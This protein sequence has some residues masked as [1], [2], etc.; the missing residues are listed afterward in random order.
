MLGIYDT[1]L[2]GLAVTKEILKLLPEL[3]LVYLADQNSLPL[4]SKTGD[5]IQAIT[6]NGVEILFG[7]GCDLVLLACNTATVNTIRHLQQVWLL[8]QNLNQTHNI[9]GVSQP[10]L[11]ILED[12]KLELSHKNGLLLATKATYNSGFYQSQVKQGGYFK[13]ETIGCPGLADAVE[14]QDSNQDTNMVRQVL[15]QICE[16]QNIDI[17]NLEYLVLGCTH[18]CW[19]EAEIKEFFGQ[20]I[21][22]INP[23]QIIARKLQQYLINH[24]KYLAQNQNQKFLINNPQNLEKYTSF[25]QKE[26]APDLVFELV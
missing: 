24:P 23:A 7:L 3:D 18:Y 15:M 25:V 8:E 13:L 26:L 9:L 22:V 21:A 10:L 17:P 16:T 20:K 2:G 6:K 14:I 11:E 1:G 5:Q 4:G 12:R 19:I